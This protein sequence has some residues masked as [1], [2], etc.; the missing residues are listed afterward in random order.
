MSIVLKNKSLNITEADI[1]LCSDMNLLLDWKIKIDTEINAIK[2]QIEQAKIEYQFDDK[3]ADKKWLL[4]AITAKK[5][6][7]QFSQLIQNRLKKLRT[8]QKEENRIAHDRAFVLSAKKILDNDTFMKIV[9][10]ANQVLS[11]S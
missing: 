9:S 3:P 5:F 1:A 4:K 2:A 6:H 8:E 7:G 11:I 10:E